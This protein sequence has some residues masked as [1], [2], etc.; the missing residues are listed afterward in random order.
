M[1]AGNPLAYL[2]PQIAT[3]MLGAPMAPAAGADMGVIASLLGAQPTAMSA[4]ASDIVRRGF[5]PVGAAPAPVNNTPAA[6]PVMQASQTAAGDVPWEKLSD[7]QLLQASGSGL[8]GYAMHA[9]SE[10][11]R[12]GTSIRDIHAQQAAQRNR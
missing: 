1:P 12:R 8:P 7:R 2:I 9:M 10:A 11:K 4:G 6:R 3:P 5:A